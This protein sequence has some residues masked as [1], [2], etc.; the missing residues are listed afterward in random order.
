VYGQC[1]ELGL[2]Y[3]SEAAVA[4]YL[5]R[6]FPGAMLPE[7]FA[8]VLH[9]RTSGNPLFLVTM[10]DTLMQQGMLRSGGTGW[11]FVGALATVAA[12]IFNDF[13]QSSGRTF[14]GVRG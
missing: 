9:R 13:S 10:G 1:A 5:A 11:S 3:F 6:R 4:T 8:R 12:Y 7:G 14:S 2:A